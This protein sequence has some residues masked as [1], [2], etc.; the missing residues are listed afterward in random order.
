MD[1]GLVTEV[2]KNLNEFNDPPEGNCQ[3]SHCSTKAVGYY[4]GWRICG[5]H[6]MKI[7]SNMWKDL[8]GTTIVETCEIEFSEEA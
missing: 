4:Y 5:E 6:Q 2:P 1:D 8:L 7:V 3:I